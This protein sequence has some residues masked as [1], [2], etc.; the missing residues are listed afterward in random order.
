MRDTAF[1]FVLVAICQYIK[2]VSTF[3]ILEC[4]CNLPS[5]LNMSCVF[6]S[7]VGQFFSFFFVDA[8]ES[9]AA[10]AVHDIPK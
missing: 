6:L 2:N 10:E 5:M 9:V 1:V 4:G 7:M 3:V 8:I